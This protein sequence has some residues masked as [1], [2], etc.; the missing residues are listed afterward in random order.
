MDPS[1]AG[2][3]GGKPGGAAGG[4]GGLM[5]A[6]KGGAGGGMAALRQEVNKAAANKAAA[7]AAAAAAA[8][9]AR[10]AAKRKAAGGMAADLVGAKGPAPLPF[11]I[12]EV[13]QIL[14][15]ADGHPRSFQ[16]LGEQLPAYDFS[17]GGQLRAALLTNTHVAAVEGGL[18][19]KSEHGIRCKDDL[20]RHIRNHPSGAPAKRVRDAYKTVQED[21]ERLRAE[22]KVFK[23]WNSEVADDVY[24]P[25]DERHKVELRPDVV[26]LFLETRPPEEPG[27]LVAAVERLGQRS[28]L[29]N[30]D[31]RVKVAMPEREK[32]ARK[33]RQQAPRTVT[34]VH[35][36]QLFQGA[37][38]ETIDS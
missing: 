4:G 26:S 36:P 33:R 30:V 34:N 22:G 23:F 12:K 31:R 24:F 28:A 8:A 1:G 32:K 16:E 18:A 37:A 13:L 20:L 27:E 7:D 6:W 14:R 35:L 17:D 2:P 19:Y 38:P 25:V 29:K 9:A 10:A 3:G 21:A 5:Q 15:D 11:Q